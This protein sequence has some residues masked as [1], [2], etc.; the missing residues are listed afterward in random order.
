MYLKSLWTYMDLRDNA[1]T[2]T[3][4]ET[5]HKSLRYLLHNILEDMRTLRLFQNFFGMIGWLSPYWIYGKESLMFG[6]NST[7]GDFGLR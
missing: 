1:V 7:L 6:A 2:K 3:T 4:I 5:S